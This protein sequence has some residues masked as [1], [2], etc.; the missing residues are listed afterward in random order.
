MTSLLL[1]RYYCQCKRFRISHRTI[2]GEQTLSAEEVTQ[3]CRN[4]KNVLDA[5]GA[6]LPLLKTS[7]AGMSIASSVAIRAT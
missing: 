4:L 3:E 1:A 6:V 7:M 5:K 2:A